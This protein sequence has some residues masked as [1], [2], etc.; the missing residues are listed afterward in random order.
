MSYW[1][2]LSNIFLQ[3]IGG[4][5]LVVSILAIILLFMILFLVRSTKHVFISI[6][7]I[8]M[9]FVTKQGIMPSWV[10]FISLAATGIFVAKGIIDLFFNPG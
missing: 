2:S 8:F 10:F 7:L 5:Y 9:Y 1:E 4:S 3:D 6:I